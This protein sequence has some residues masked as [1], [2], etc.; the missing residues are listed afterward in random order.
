MYWYLE[1]MVHQY[2]MLKQRGPNCDSDHYLVTVKTKDRLATIDDNKS[3]K[4]K[5]WKVDKLKEP[6]QSQLYQETIKTKL[7]ALRTELTENENEQIEQQWNII[8]NKTNKLHGL[9]SQANYTDRAT[10]ACWRS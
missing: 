6:E 5:K 1:D 4:R 2:E 9:S 10:I 8:K 7:E 3:Y